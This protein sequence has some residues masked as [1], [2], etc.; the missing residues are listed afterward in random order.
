MSPR[1]EGAPSPQPIAAPL[2]PAPASGRIRAVVVDDEP[3]AREELTHLL[4]G[5]AAVEVIGEASNGVEAL[6]LIERERPQLVFLDIRMPGLDGFQLV[7][8]LSR[9]QIAAQI[10]FVTAYDQYAIKAFEVSAT[11]YLLKPVERKRLEAAIE[12]AKG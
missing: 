6:E 1:S 10:V 4:A 5:M 7:R 8:Q 9:R 11:D 12:K 3:L 2:P